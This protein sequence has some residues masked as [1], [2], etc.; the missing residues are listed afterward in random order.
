MVEIALLAL[1]SVLAAVALAL[2]QVREPGALGLWLAATAAVFGAGICHLLLTE[3]P[4]MLLPGY[5][6]AVFYPALLLAGARVYAGRSVP[7][8]LLP[9]ALVAGV[10]RAGAALLDWTTVSLCVGFATQPTA[11][12]GAALGVLRSSRPRRPSAHRALG[13]AL[14]GVAA[15]EVATLVSTPVGTPIG[16]PLLALW[17]L[18]VPVLLALQVVAA[19]DRAHDALRRARDELEQRVAERTKELAG[20]LAALRASEERYRTVSGLSS[21]YSFAVRLAP[22]L[23]VE[24]EWATDALEEISGYR[25]EEVRGTGWLSRVVESDRE[26]V[27]DVLREVLAGERKEMELRILSRAGEIRTLALRFGTRREETG[28]VVRIVGAARDVSEIKRGEAERRRLDAIVRQREH[29]ESLG[30]LASGVAHDF[31]NVLTV[32]RGNA[33]LALADLAPEAP[34]REWLERIEAVTRHAAELT[35]QMLTYAGRAS[36]ALRPLDLSALV[37]D[38]LDLLRASVAEKIRLDVQLAEELPAVQGDPTP[39]RQVLLNLVGNAADA[40]GPDGGVVEI[41]TGSCHLGAPELTGALPTS[42]AA[43]GAYVYLEVADR[44]VGIA[45]EHQAR[46]FEPF[47]TTRASGRGLGL[48]AVFGIVAAHSGVIRVES[49]PG[50]STRFRVLL[51]VG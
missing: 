8:W 50:E 27:R 11:A 25:S 39:L 19:S 18:A 47:F 21:D 46:I 40:S 48:A 28:G 2:R 13:S 6:L 34:A 30:V 37:R 10:V 26:R 3:L 23:S 16:P 4:W 9:L 20:S 49:S 5:T 32:I 14:L 43:P 41:R 45:P 24:I 36:V 1:L 42:D 15:L 51:P 31:N 17:I 33:G 35:D 22:D 44:G 12:L 7:A 38:A 29:V